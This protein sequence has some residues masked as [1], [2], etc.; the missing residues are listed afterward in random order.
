[1]NE[2]GKPTNKPV[3]PQKNIIL[4]SKLES[5]DFLNKVRGHTEVSERGPSAERRGDG[6]IG[7]KQQPADGSEQ[8]A[9]QS[10]PEKREARILRVSLFALPRASTRSR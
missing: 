8:P 6:E 7:H 2:M 10:A 3:N 9:L 4:K 5:V 1:M